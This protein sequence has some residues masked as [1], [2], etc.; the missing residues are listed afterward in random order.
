MKTVLKIAGFVG[1]AANLCSCDNKYNGILYSLLGKIV[2]A[3]D[4]NCATTI[5]KKYSYRFKIVTLDGQVVNAGGS[6]TGGSLNRNTGLLSRANEIETLKKQTTVLEQKSKDAENRSIEISREYS[7][8]EAQLLGSQADLSNLRQDL[9][10][11]E[12]EKRACDNELANAGASVENSMNEI[13]NC[14][15]RI[16]TLEKIKIPQSSSLL[17]SIRKSLLPKKR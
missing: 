8:F 10:R 1:V 14:R 17:N 4:L 11:L 7:A 5:A 12:A 6:L 2:I 15:R 13:T 16:E 3:E 9:V